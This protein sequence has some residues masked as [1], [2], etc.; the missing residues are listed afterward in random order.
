MKTKQKLHK[1]LWRGLG[2][3]AIFVAGVMS[4]SS[5]DK[6]DLDK[7]DPEGWGASIYSYLVEAGNYR[8]TVRLIQDLGQE[9]VLAKTG[10]KT[11]FVADDD[12]F[13]RF[14]ANNRWGVKSYE[15]LTES[16]KKLLLYGSMINNSYQI[17][18][19]SSVEGPIEG[20]C[21]RRSTASTVY[22]SVPCIKVQDL[23]NMKPE[24][25]KNNACW[26]KFADRKDVVIMQDMTTTPM[27]HF[28]E[29]F[30]T[31]N[32]ILNSD[33]NFLFGDKIDRQS[34]DAIV[35]GVNLRKMNIKCSNG[36]IHLLD[37]VMLPLDN[38]A[39]LIAQNP[40][41]STFSKMI[42]RFSAPFYAGINVTEQYNLY[43]NANVD[44]VFQKR[45]FATM[46]QNFSLLEFDDDNK[47]HADVLK[48]DPGWNR[49]YI[50]DE[51]D[52][53]G[54]EAAVNRD[55]AF[56][57]APSNKAMDEYFT[58]GAG[59]ILVE[60]YGSVDNI[61][62]DVIKKLVN[63]NFITSFKEYGVKSKFNSILNDAN[64]PMN[65]DASVID[66]VM[67]GCNGVVYVTNTVY[68]PTAFVSVQYP[69]VVNRNMKLMNW[70]IEKNKYSVYLNSLNA[71]YS[72]FIPTNN[73]MLQ[74]INP[75]SYGKKKGE[76]YRFHYDEKLANPVWASVFEYDM[77]KHEVG[78]SL[79]EDRDEGRLVNIMKDV[80]DNCI[81]V[82]TDVEDGNE[83][84]RTKA[85]T[86]LRI[87]NA[88]AGAAGMT[89]E[90]SYQI[91]DSHEPLHV[92]KVYD[93]TPDPATKKAGNGKCYILE[94]KPILTTKKSVIDIM[95][96]HPEMDAMREL[97]E[98]SGLLEVIHDEKASPSENFSM[99]NAYHY[100]VYVPSNEAIRDLQNKGQLPTWEQVE[101]Y[102][103]AGIDEK[104]DADSAA[105]V[106]FIK[107]H[108]QDGSLFIGS[109]P[110]EQQKYETSYIGSNGKFERIY[111]T[112][113]K[114]NIEIRTS[115]T[116]PN[117]RKVVKKD[118]LYNL[119]AREYRLDAKSNDLSTRVSTSSAAVIHMIDGPLIHQ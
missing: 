47:H 77:E 69:T 98:S 92:T 11:L 31:N 73:A 19:L 117:P 52:N 95:R 99:F 32:H 2:A 63:N 9:S 4:F 71:Y 26:A 12:A 116:D 5:C 42:E 100:T 58:E 40:N 80:L 20:Q 94:D 24:D 8:N 33:V 53:N 97:I 93:Q 108:I 23:P 78:D 21:V 101:K 41:T 15:Q 3:A 104:A 38:M 51:Y 113:T 34:G 49:Y 119:M 107:F 13:D 76:V 106:D 29:D 27:V 66:E 30:L 84:Y 68:S 102:R 67:M 39:N 7:T 65:V 60:Q 54:D 81:I 70:A 36:F 17:N 18:N 118:G 10:S 103:E 74:Y 6:Y 111:T 1:S 88:K 43:H 105:I 16:Q 89:V 110:V 83:Y 96:E 114:D 44:S 86:T 91:N 115:L 64:D 14:Y 90:G 46:S 50:N 75:A 59:S 35:N 82:N 28:V 45:Y 56:I 62:N 25:L 109:E 79:R 48:F 37:E 61:P 22:D 85:G 57:L 55:M 72:F 112:L 87:K